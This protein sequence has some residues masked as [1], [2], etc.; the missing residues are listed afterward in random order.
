MQQTEIACQ[1]CCIM[2]AEMQPISQKPLHYIQQKAPSLPQFCNEIKIKE[3]YKI[4]RKRERE[5]K[6]A[7]N[8]WT[9]LIS[10]PINA[11]WEKKVNFCSKNQ[12]CEKYLRLDSLM[13]KNTNISKKSFF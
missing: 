8:V 1:H 6:M 12:I 2:G 7:F 10:T 13:R 3:K 5:I 9:F 4:A 11:L